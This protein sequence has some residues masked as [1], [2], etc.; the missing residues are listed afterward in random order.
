MALAVDHGYARGT[1]R[2]RE[3]RRIE[4]YLRHGTA[5]D[6]HILM[7]L[8]VQLDVDHDRLEEAGYGGRR[9]EDLADEIEGAGVT[10][11]GNCAD[12]PDVRPLGIQVGRA[13]QE[14]SALLV[15]ARDGRQ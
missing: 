15:F 12:V 1:R 11:G 9:A 7:R 5:V 4:K 13:D 3:A 6:V 10:A 14:Q 2:F 8:A